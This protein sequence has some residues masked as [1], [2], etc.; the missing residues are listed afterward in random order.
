MAQPLLK[1]PIVSS[2]PSLVGTGNGTLAIDRLTHFTTAQTYTLTCIGTS[3]NT[4][5]SVVGSLDGPVGIATVGSQ[6]FDDDLKIFLTIQQGA[7]PFVVGDTFTVTVVNGTDLNQD[8]IDN[9][10]ELTQKNFGLGTK[11]SLSGDQNIR[12]SDAAVA[13]SRTVGDLRYTA[14]TAGP[15]GNN[16]TLQYLANI[17]AI[18]A[19]LPSFGGFNWTAVAAGTGGN[20][21]TIQYV[22]DVLAGSETATRVGNAVTVHIQSGVTTRAQVK[23]A[24]D[25][26]PT[27]AALVTYVIVGSGAVTFFAA[28]NLSGGANAVG[29]AGAPAVQVTGAAIRVYFPTGGATAA[30]IK[31]AVDAFPAAAALVNTTIVGNGADPQ[32]VGFGPGNLI[33]G[34]SRFFAHNKHELTEPGSFV[35][36]N[37]SIKAQD[38]RLA[39]NLEV[40]GEGRFT[41]IVQLP[42]IPSVKSYLDRLIEDNKISLRTSDH[43]R[44]NWQKP[45]LSF[46][47]DIVIDFNDSALSNIVP[48]ANSPVSIADGEH[49]YVILQRENAS[50]LT[51]VVAATM[52]T[53]VNAFRIASRF[54]DHLILWDNTLLR[55][56]KSIRIGESAA[57]GTVKCDLVDGVDTTLP[58]GTGVT[59]DGVAV[60]NNTLVLFTNLSSGN[61]RVYKV[62]GVG[63][64]LVWT[65]QS[66]YSEGL[67]PIVGDD[68]LIRY[69]SA[70]ALARGTYSG[71]GWNFND[72]VRYFNGRDFW[73]ISSIKTQVLAANQISS[74]VF[75][76]AAVGSENIII[77]YSVIR[78]TRKQTGHMYIAADG[79]ANASLANQSAPLGDVGMSFWADYSGGSLR[80]RYSS[81]NSSGV[82]TIKFIVQRWSDGPGGPTGV[83]SYTATTQI[84]VTAP[85]LNSQIIFND[86]GSY[87]ADS[88][89]TYDKVNKIIALGGLD[90]TG[91]SA[92]IVLSDNISSFTNL[93]SYTATPLPFAEFIYSIKRGTNYLIGRMMITNDTVNTAMSGDFTEL[94]ACG[95]EL[96]AIISGANVVIQYKSTNTGTSGTLRV[97]YRRWGLA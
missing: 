6:F 74:T 62:T 27:I 14:D 29:A 19:T 15:A 13:A 72:Y 23:T 35:E 10:D 88:G 3:P 32:Y 46:E 45:L 21:I 59:I 76:I 95:I 48:V 67:D 73:E 33:G 34:N 97:G 87:G 28:T 79:S 63:T 31:T 36:G 17:A 41:G 9:Y 55:E 44:I 92:P 1:D 70:F 64:S 83:P 16:I 57:E 30:Q 25:A 39:G 4:V 40:D 89:F 65:P 8:N 5:F 77:S 81:D 94:G 47:A 75:S 42:G 93:F 86:G 84:G 96:R 71:T 2:G 53:D 91:M 24:M 90:M 22:N 61:N 52:P 56:G 54:G 80:L 43:S 60:T 20:A 38:A 11:G 85:G 66:V 18:Q 12:Y 68:V 7:T 58:T 51:P 82:P 50:S 26:V 78:G 69:G 37:A 49:L